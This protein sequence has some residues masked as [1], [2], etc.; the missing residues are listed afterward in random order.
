MLY[1]VI[2]VGVIGVMVDYWG[3]SMA[4]GFLHDFEGWVVFMACTILSAN[5]KNFGERAIPDYRFD[6]AKVVVSFAADFLGT[7]LSPVERNNFV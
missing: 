1:E 6:K 4:E 5:M 3:Q 7:W 2:T